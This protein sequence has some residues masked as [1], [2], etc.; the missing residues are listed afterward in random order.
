MYFDQKAVLKAV[1]REN[2]LPVVSTATALLF[3]LGAV[4]YWQGEKPTNNLDEAYQAAFKWAA[5]LSLR[6][7]DTDC[8]KPPAAS[9]EAICVVS[10]RLDHGQSRKFKLACSTAI[11][12]NGGCRLIARLP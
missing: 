8:Q 12:D 10:E 2:W 5:M 3:I 1:I 7:T 6:Q 11:K 9:Q 4:L